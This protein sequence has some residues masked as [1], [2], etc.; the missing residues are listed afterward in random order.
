M[1]AYDNLR[2]YFESGLITQLGDKNAM[3]LLTLVSFVDEKGC[4]YPTQSQIAERLGV[5][6]RAMHD[7]IH[8]LLSFRWQGSP[9]VKRIKGQKVPLFAHLQTQ[10]LFLPIT[11]ESA[12]KI[13]PRKRILEYYKKLYLETYQ[14]VPHIPRENVS[15]KVMARLLVKWSPEQIEEGMRVAFREYERWA[16]V[17]YPR[18]VLGQFL[19]WLLD[20]VQPFIQREVSPPDFTEILHQIGGDLS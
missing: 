17:R 10:Y 9:I 6:R 4:C 8:D 3:T 19:N 14:E 2:N 20:E 18:P 16:T 15:L 1:I 7:R 11:L 13:D 12:P 5:S